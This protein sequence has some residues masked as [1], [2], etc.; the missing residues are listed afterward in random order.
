MLLDGSEAPYLN[1]PDNLEVDGYGNIIIQEDPGNNPQL[2]RMVAYRIAD[3]KLAVMSRFNE[4]MFLASKASSTF[5]TEDEETSGVLNVTNLMRKNKSDKKYYYLFVAQVHASGDA[6]FKARPDITDAAAKA[7]LAKAIE[8]GQMYL[9]T[10]T[11]WN[12]VYGG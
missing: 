7:E 5:I 12:T 11:N 10:V 4:A 2:S 9:M 8:A 6:L 3:G 1:K